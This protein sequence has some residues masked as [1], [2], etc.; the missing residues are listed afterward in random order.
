MLALWGLSALAQR[1][2]IPFKPGSW[3]ISSVQT[4]PDGRTVSSETNVCAAGQADF[5][6]RAQAGL[7]CKP[8]RSTLVQGGIRVRVSCEYNGDSLHS[9]IRSDVVERFSDQGRSFTATG[10]STTDTVYAG[11]PPQ[12][13]SAHLQANAHRVGPCQ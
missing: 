7:Q 8:P 12:R 5:W 1:G 4:M 2:P 3:Q 9:E 11:H 6:K 10:T 13:T